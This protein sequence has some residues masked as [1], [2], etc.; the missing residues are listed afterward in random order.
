MIPIKDISKGSDL[1]PSRYN[2]YFDVDGIDYVYNTLYVGLAG[3]DKKTYDLISKKEISKIDPSVIESLREQN[4][5]VDSKLDELESYKFFNSSLRFGSGARVL[6]ITLIP[7][8]NCN[9]VC[10]YCS[11]GQ[12]KKN[13]NI[14]IEDVDKIISF[15]E[16]TIIHSRENGV[17]I[18]HIRANLFGGEPLLNK[19]AAIH[20]CYRM[21]ELAEKTHCKIRFQ[22]TTNLTLLDDELLKMFIDVDMH[23]QAT[24]DGTPESHDKKRIDKKGRGTFSVIVKNLEKLNKA[25][26][27]KNT[28]IRINIDEKDFDSAERAIASVT[29]YSDDIYFGY[30]EKFNGFNDGC[31]SCYDNCISSRAEKTEVLNKIRRKYVGKIPEEFGK[32]SPCALNAANKF[33]I[34]CNLRVYKCE[35]SINM[36]EVSVGYIDENSNLVPNHNYYKQLNHAPWDHEKCRNCILLPLCAGGCAARSYIA[37]NKRDGNLCRTYCM[38]DKHSLT[39]YLKNYVKRLL[40]GV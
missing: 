23:C 33:F 30:I 20:Y 40:E 19:R 15:A 25:G 8:Y 37:S 9:L 34:D 24:I 11:Q 32:L 28:T 29:P 6:A 26:L 13:N 10:P 22:V 3:L 4:F 35:L 39:V 38:C 2:F 16:K 27:R 36:P 12:G 5:L 31:A 18:T 21:K 14:S 7:T 17:P 1:V